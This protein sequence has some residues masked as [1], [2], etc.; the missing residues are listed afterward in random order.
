MGPLTPAFG[1]EDVSALKRT[2]GPTK[3][4]ALL[5]RM[6]LWNSRVR[7]DGYAIKGGLESALAFAIDRNEFL[8]SR[9]FPGTK[10]WPF[11]RSLVG[12]ITQ[13]LDLAIYL[14]CVA[15]EPF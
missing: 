10:R 13:G 9:Q 7:A 12:P 6:F 4:G 15:R 5:V 11:L 8:T 1:H 2:T 14:I 3:K